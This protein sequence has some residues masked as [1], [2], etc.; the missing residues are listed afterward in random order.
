[1]FAQ[2]LSAQEE[3]EVARRLKSGNDSRREEDQARLRRVLAPPS[4]PTCVQEV[5]QPPRINY[6]AASSLSLL[7]FSFCTLQEENVSL[8]IPLF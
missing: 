6:A 2:L 4:N 1:M 8:I 7:F 3:E 5:H